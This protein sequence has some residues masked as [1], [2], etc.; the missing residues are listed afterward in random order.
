MVLLILMLL[1]SCS[2]AFGFAMTHNMSMWYPV[3]YSGVILLGMSAP[4]IFEFVSV[5]RS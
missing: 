2:W 5:R 3:M 1:L 4:A